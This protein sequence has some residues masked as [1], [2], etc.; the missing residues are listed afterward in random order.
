MEVVADF[1]CN[2]I[3]CFSRK[4]SAN[5]LF[6]AFKPRFSVTG[7]VD[8]EKRELWC[9]SS[10][11]PATGQRPG[12]PYEPTASQP[13]SLLLPQPQVVCWALCFTGKLRVGL[14]KA[15]T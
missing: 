7:L 9:H 11:E 10:S 8:G 2:Q 3:F 6:L 12:V 5:V 14:H 1:F 13:V 15:L 4:Q